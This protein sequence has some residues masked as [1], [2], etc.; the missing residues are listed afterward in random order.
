MRVT[1]LVKIT[2]NSLNCFKYNVFHFK[3]F[4]NILMTW[5]TQTI[6]TKK[7]KK[8]IIVSIDYMDRFKKKK[9]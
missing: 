1:Y 2:E 4:V 3:I 5:K 6:K 9:E 8:S 7:L